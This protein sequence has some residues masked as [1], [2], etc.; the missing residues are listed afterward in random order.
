MNATL[1]PDLRSEVAAIA[2]QAGCE[3]FDLAYDG[4][5]LRI[6]LDRIDSP[7]TLTDCTTVS[8]QISAFLDVSDFGRKQYTLEVSSPG[9]DRPLRGADDYRRF[10][11]H[12]ANITYTPTSQT[13]T[14]EGRVPSSP[15][16]VSVV[17]RLET[18]DETTDGGAVVLIEPERETRH[19]IPVTQV[20]RAR[21]EIEL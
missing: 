15:T 9:L 12:L 21:L 7:V 19:V 4:K 3:V 11:G 16:A 13:S 17:G 10:V 18:F 5:V 6:M 8:R 2:A 14:D 20:R 1:H